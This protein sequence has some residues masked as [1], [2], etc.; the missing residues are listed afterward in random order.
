MTNDYCLI[1]DP[2]LI[3]ESGEEETGTPPDGV[4]IPHRL[5]NKAELFVM[6][7][8]LSLGVGAIVLALLTR[9]HL[10]AR[11]IAPADSP[12]QVE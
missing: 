2:D 4:R 12:I 8:A 5:D 1:S 11:Q 3:P 9:K 7:L 10:F 6:A